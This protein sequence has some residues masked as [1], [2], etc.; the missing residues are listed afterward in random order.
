[1]L[2]E[3]GER[4]RR[5][6]EEH[7]SPVA[8]EPRT[9]K[10]HEQEDAH[11][12][13]HAAAEIHEQRKHADI[14]EHMH[15]ELEVE[16]AAIHADAD[17]RGQR[18]R[19]VKA[20]DE[21]MMRASLGRNQRKGRRVDERRDEEQNGDRDTIAV[22]I[23]ERL[24]VRIG[25]LVCTGDG[26]AHHRRLV[27]RRRCRVPVFGTAVVAPLD[28]QTLAD[29]LIHAAIRAGHHALGLA[30]GPALMPRR[31]RRGHPAQ[32]PPEDAEEDENDQKSHVIQATRQTAKSITESPNRAAFS[33]PPRPP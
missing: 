6:V 17:Q 16:A 29:R 9:G 5:G 33:A 1:M 18:G 27:I 19:Q 3:H 21:Q 11:A 32:Q 31:A 10:G 25:D 24:P 8:N 12:A 20:R 4:R 23:A 22:E 7:Q 2:V 26:F 13:A 30:D 14:D 28:L 15:I